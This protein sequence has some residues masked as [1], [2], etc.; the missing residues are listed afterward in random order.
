MVVDMAPD[1]E[2]LPRVLLDDLAGDVTEAVEM[3]EATPS[4]E[5]TDR[6][7]DAVEPLPD[8]EELPIEDEPEEDEACK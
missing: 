1:E 4:V 2:D 3:L 5:E 7:D 6:S 8:E